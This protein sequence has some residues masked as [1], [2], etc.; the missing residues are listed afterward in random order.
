[1]PAGSWVTER[2]GAQVE[3]EASKMTPTPTNWGS[4]F[5]VWLEVIAGVSSS[6]ADAPLLPRRRTARKRRVSMATRKWSRK[7]RTAGKLQWGSGF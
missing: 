7:G 1:M 4:A 2:S 6:A 5:A 3:A